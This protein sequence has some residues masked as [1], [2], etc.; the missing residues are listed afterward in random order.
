MLLTF[1]EGTPVGKLIEIGGIESYVTGD[2]AHA[3]KKLL[4]YFS[5]VIG[6][7]FDNAQLI[8]DE[9]AK[10]GFFV[11][12]PD[13]FNG[14]PVPLNP[15]A[16][17][18]L[19]AGWRPKHSPEITEPI[20]DQVVDAVYTQYKPKFSTAIGFCF[21]ARYAIRLLGTGKI[22]AA[23]VFHPSGVAIKDVKAIKGHLL[24]T[25]PDNDRVYTTELR[26]ETED[27]LKE[28]SKTTGIKYRQNLL[29][30]IGHGFAARGDISDPWIKYSKEKAVY[31]TIEWFAIADNTQ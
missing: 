13:L 10:A 26:R 24:I 6:H 31:D 4:F 12:L 1:S 20:V 3:S 15:P 8:A 11:V 28:L 17:F 7:K 22:Q 18:D 16:G 23:S 5:D 21:G 30:G 19:A 27:A 14:D 9:Y 25:A 29:H 2:E